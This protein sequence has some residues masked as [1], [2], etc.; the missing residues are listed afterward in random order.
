MVKKKETFNQLPSNEELKELFAYV[1]ETGK[2]LYKK[3][4]HSKQAVGKEIKSRSIKVNGKKINVARIVW[5]MNHPDWDGLC[6]VVHKNGDGKDHRIENLFLRKKGD[7]VRENLSSEFLNEI[8]H[9]DKVSGD[10]SSKG[11]LYHYRDKR[12]KLEKPSETTGYK[13]VSIKAVRYPQH[14]I[15]WK[16]HNPEWDLLSKDQIDHIN[17]KRSD[18]RIE[19]LRLSDNSTNRRNMKIFST[20]TSGVA[21][22]YFCKKSKKWIARITVDYEDISLGSHENKDDAIKARKKAEEKY[23]FHQNHGGFRKEQTQYKREHKQK[24]TV[25]INTGRFKGITWAKHANK[26]SV[27]VMIKSKKYHGGLFKSL[28]EAKEGLMALQRKLGL[29]EKI[30]EK[31]KTVAI[32]NLERSRE[33]YEGKGYFSEDEKNEKV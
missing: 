18:N 3:T 14:R 29:E 26:F 1:E 15:V 17:G 21:G 22:V 32:K 11:E 9:Y 25:K 7:R 30:E 24:P 13:Y 5:K 6:E 23:G 2:L 4:F 19:N 31:T 27:F 12:G 16:M 8:F 33:M 10:L 20:N 28:E